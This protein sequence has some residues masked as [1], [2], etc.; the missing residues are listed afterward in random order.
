VATVEKQIN[1][2][3]DQLVD[4][5]NLLE[6]QFAL[7]SATAQNELKRKFQDQQERQRQNLRES[8][9]S[10]NIE[11][12]RQHHCTMKKMNEMFAEM[13]EQFTEKMKLIDEINETV[14]TLK[15]N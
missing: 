6:T 14:K 9:T 10:Y 12:K 1:M 5:V 4:K 8:E 11:L 3:R 13:K 15:A 7:N 2:L